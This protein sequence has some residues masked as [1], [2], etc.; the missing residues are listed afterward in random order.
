MLEE[1]WKA[2]QSSG[3][4]IYHPKAAGSYDIAE[5]LDAPLF[6]SIPYW[7]LFAQ[8]RHLIPPN[9][10]VFDHIPIRHYPCQ[11]RSM[12]KNSLIILPCYEGMM[13]MK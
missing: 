6:I 3:V 4:I 10:L 5:K 9:R 11:T 8:A 7:A 12:E 13:L 2:A 1:E